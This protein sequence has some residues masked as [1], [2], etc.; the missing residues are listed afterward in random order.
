MF[1]DRQH[2]GK[3]LAGKLG[4][5]RFGRTPE[6]R[7]NF[8]IV[9]GLARGGIVVAKSIAEGIGIPFDVLVVKKIPSPTNSELALGA[10]AS[11]GMVILHEETIKVL[12]VDAEYI[13]S[14]IFRLDSIIRQKTILY[15]KGNKDLT[16][17]GKRVILADDGMATGA[18]MEAAVAW[19]KAQHA[20]HVTVALPVAPYEALAQIR[21]MADEVIIL[22][23]PEHFDSVGRVYEHFEQVEDDKV[24][25]YLQ[26]RNVH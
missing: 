9:I 23:T 15:R 7:L 5:V 16:V 13:Q 17:T 24:R 14:Q 19:C 21:G 4:L 26:E 22:E 12:G 3:L 8:D 2:A 1:K 18:T 20:A 25:A 10:I 6:D 11:D